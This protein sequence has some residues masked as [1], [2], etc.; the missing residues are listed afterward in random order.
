MTGGKILE[1]GSRSPFL[2]CHGLFDIYNHSHP[3]GIPWHPVKWKDFASIFIYLGFLWNLVDRTVGLPDAKRLK[4]LEKV[5]S[6]LELLSRGGR[7]TLKDA[8]S[9]N[10]TLSH[11]SFVIPHGRAYLANLSSFIAHFGSSSSSKFVARY[12]PSS[13]VHDLK[14]WLSVLSA[15]SPARTL[16]SRGDVQD[17]DLWVDAS[18]DWGIG[19]VMGSR[20]DAWTLKEGWKG[21]G[22]DIGWLEA[23]AV[24]LAVLTLFNLG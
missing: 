13:V 1:D 18:T 3:L 20:W 2:F 5:S 12:P 23:I 22:Q 7:L 17:L 24:E 4:Y 10:G 16:S 15:P 6:L 21:Q 8:M 19:L 9:I 14:W 11:I